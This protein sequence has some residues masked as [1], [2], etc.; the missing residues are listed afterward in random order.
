MFERIALDGHDEPEL[1]AVCRAHLDVGRDAIDVGAKVG[2]YTVL[3]ARAL[4]GR[5]VLAVEPTPAA[6]GR[7]RSN[8]ERNEVSDRTVIFEG[9]A[10][11]GRLPISIVD[12]R[13]EY[14]SLGALVHDA[15]AD[16]PGSVLDVAAT[17]LDA[18]VAED[19]LAPGFVKI[20]VE[21][22]SE[23]LRVAS[24]TLRVHRPVVL[25]E[26]TGPLLEAQGASAEAVLHLLRDAGYSLMDPVRPGAPPADAAT[27]TCWRCPLNVADGRSKRRG[28]ACPLIWEDVPLF[29]GSW[30]RLWDHEWPYVAGRLRGSS[31]LAEEWPLTPRPSSG[32]RAR[33]SVGSRPLP[34]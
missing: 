15:V 8:L 9:A 21:G 16:A 31:R 11:A 6:L 20:D 14:A 7:L 13:E 3:M 30:S 18:L 34:C 25:A 12:G 29:V 23:T 5:R 33:L 10:A 1:A 22:A 17:T 24:E 28:L 4:P 26:P 27:G 2:F 32:R 19:G